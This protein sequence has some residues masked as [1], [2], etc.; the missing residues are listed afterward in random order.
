[1]LETNMKDEILFIYQYRLIGVLIGI[2]YIINFFGYRFICRTCPRIKV[3]IP[4]LGI[5]ESKL[6]IYNKHIHHW[7]FFSV[8]LCLTL[9]IRLKNQQIIYFLQGLSVSL[10]IHGLIYEDRFD[11]SCSSSKERTK[12]CTLH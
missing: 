7:L 5:K 11:F 10:I 6:I 3:N 12:K 8:I 9:F 4:F 2:I 1:M